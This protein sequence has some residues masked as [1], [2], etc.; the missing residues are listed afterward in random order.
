MD[1][2]NVGENSLF[3]CNPSISTFFAG[4]IRSV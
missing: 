1:V 3:G 2:E 4:V